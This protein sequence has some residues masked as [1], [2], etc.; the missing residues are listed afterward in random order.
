MLYLN[1]Y[2]APFIIVITAFD[3]CVL[4]TKVYLTNLY[5]K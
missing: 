2:Y 4:H 5:E 3:I 1:K